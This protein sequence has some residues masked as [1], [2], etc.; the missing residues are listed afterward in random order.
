MSTPAIRVGG[1][2][3]LVICKDRHGDLMVSVHATRQSADDAITALMASYADY[4]IDPPY[5]WTERAYGRARGWLRYV[6]TNRADG[7]RA[8]IERTTLQGDG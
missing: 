5:Q 8:Y 3:F 2:I 1:E 7:P 4:K 6:D